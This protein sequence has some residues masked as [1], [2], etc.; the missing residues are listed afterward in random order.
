M[1]DVLIVSTFKPPRHGQA[2]IFK[3]STFKTQTQAPIIWTQGN[4]FWTQQVNINKPYNFRHK[5]CVAHHH[6]I[7]VRFFKLPSKNLRD[8]KYCTSLNQ[9]TCGPQLTQYTE[10]KIKIMPRCQDWRFPAQ[11]QPSPLIK[12]KQRLKFRKYIHKKLLRD[13]FVIYG[14]GS[15][16]MATIFDTRIDFRLVLRW[17][18]PAESN[19]N[20]NGDLQTIWYGQRKR[21]NQNPVRHQVVFVDE[22]EN[23][24]RVSVGHV[25]AVP[26]N[27]C[28]TN[29]SFWTIINQ[30]CLQVKKRVRKE[31]THKMP[32]NLTQINTL[33]LWKTSG[34]Q[35][36]SEHVFAA[37]GTWGWWTFNVSIRF[38]FE[39]N[40]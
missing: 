17:W 10:N 33:I 3:A 34:T 40:V 18:V 23:Q 31:H 6:S 25:A 26:N 19:D 38:T 28:L 11:R 29:L 5:A 36:V 7:N 13:K 37:V 4:V 35:R 15:G 12:S 2:S 30:L 20:A 27:F 1:Y 16:Y 21:K 14:S 39:V 24:R 22:K 9:L 32:V 8:I